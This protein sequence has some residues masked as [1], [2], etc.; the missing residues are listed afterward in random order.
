[1]SPPQEKYVC[2]TIHFW[3]TLKAFLASWNSRGGRCFF[4]GVGPD[5]KRHAWPI[6][7]NATVCVLHTPVENRLTLRC[8]PR[9]EI[10]DISKRSN[11]GDIVAFQTRI[12]IFINLWPKA[13]AVV[14][15]SGLRKGHN[16]SKN[17]IS[18]NQAHSS[19]AASV[20]NIL[21]SPLKNKS[22]LR[23][24]CIYLIR[25]TVHVVSGSSDWI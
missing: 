23:I 6:Q 13:N 25:V 12:V 16:I 18:F 21:P 3:C 8:T 11:Y 22:G 5:G 24:I 19:T 15:L 10:Y 17:K 4:K 14:S 7:I 1:M 2:L 20:L 9:L